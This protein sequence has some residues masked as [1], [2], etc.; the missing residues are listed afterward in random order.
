[1]KVCLPRDAQADPMPINQRLPWEL[2]VPMWVQEH[3]Y[4]GV[5]MCKCTCTWQCVCSGKH[6][7]VRVFLWR[8]EPI[9]LC[10]SLGA[11]H[12]DWCFEMRCLL[13][14]KLAHLVSLASQPAPLPLLHLRRL[15]VCTA[16]LTFC[17][18]A[19]N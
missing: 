1:M 8:P 5:H 10:C 15:Q 3:V 2:L 12:L 17:V 13:G 4:T 16:C 9:H 11:L 18:D 14:L 19:G 7:L 6:V